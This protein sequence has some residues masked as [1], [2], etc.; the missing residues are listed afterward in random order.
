MGI[1]YIFILI[2]LLIFSAFTED[3]PDAGLS[4]VLENGLE[5][6]DGEEDQPSEVTSTIEV[7]NIGRYVCVLC[8]I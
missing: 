3:C 8:I 7:P 6:S 2:Q 1:F 5:D 4:A